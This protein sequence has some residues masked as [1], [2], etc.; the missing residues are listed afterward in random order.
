MAIKNE[1]T[2]EKQLRRLDT[3]TIKINIQGDIERYI[4]NKIDEFVRE[5]KET[6]TGLDIDLNFIEVTTQ[7]SS[8]KEFIRRIVIELKTDLEEELNNGNG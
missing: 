6:V 1:E 7:N 5:T 4:D 8:K 2:N 3:A